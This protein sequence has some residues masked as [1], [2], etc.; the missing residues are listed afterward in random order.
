MFEEPLLRP[1]L[2][3][4]ET[5]TVVIVTSRAGPRNGQSTKKEESRTAPR[6]GRL[7]IATVA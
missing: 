1:G 4:P 5:V 2:S 7:G 6:T 3:A